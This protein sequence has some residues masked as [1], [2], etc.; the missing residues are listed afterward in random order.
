MPILEVEH[1]GEPSPTLRG[2]L[3][4]RIADAAADVFGAKPQ[5]TWVKLRVLPAN[6]YAENAGAPE[7]DLPVFVRITLRAPRTGDALRTEAKELAQSI[8]SVCGRPTS[9]VH[10]LYDPAA[11][12]RIAFG[13]ELI[14]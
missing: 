6:D 2:D 3:A 13:G 8:G 12:G 7:G 11:S 1:V 14:D 4:Q 5:S 9:R 10:I